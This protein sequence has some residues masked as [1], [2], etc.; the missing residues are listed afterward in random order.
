MLQLIK[1][2]V[3]ASGSVLILENVDRMS[4]QDPQE[5][6]YMM[7]DI[8]RAGVK[9]YTLHDK[10]LHEREGKDNF[11]NLMVWALAAERAHDESRVKS[12]RVR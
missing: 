5:S 9:I 11:M 12:E 4:R 7:L 3:I 1:E 6:V 10:R 2:G 8:I